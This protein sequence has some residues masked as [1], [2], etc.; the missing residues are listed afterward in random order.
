MTRGIGLDFGTTKSAVAFATPSSAAEVARFTTSD[1]DTQSFRSILY[2]GHSED[3]TPVESLTGN[4]AIERY[5]EHEGEGEW[6]LL[7]S[8]KSF[9]A[10]R[11]FLARLTRF[12]PA[13]V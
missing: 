11:L 10:S 12:K 8:L 5:L 2:C 4:R 13:S 3:H 6:R 7:Q 9:L 1:G